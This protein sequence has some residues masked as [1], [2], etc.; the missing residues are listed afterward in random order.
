MNRSGIEVGQALLELAEFI[1]AC[2]SLNFMGL[3]VYDGHLRDV[4]FNQR[5]QKIESGLEAVTGQF[6]TLK[7]EYQ[8]LKM[9]CGGNSFFHFPP[10]GQK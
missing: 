2:A 10:L 5:N 1:T 3:H 7:Q 9:I 6:E 4:D 8:G